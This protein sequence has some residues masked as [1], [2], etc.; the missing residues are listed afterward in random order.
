[1]ENLLEMSQWVDNPDYLDALES[2]KYL[3]GVIT[4]RQVSLNAINEEL[5]KAASIKSYP[6][7]A[8]LMIEQ[9]KSTLEVQLQNLAQTLEE[10]KNQAEYLSFIDANGLVLVE[11]LN[12]V[13][14][15]DVSRVLLPIIPTL[16]MRGD[17]ESEFSGTLEGSAYGGSPFLNIQKYAPLIE[18]VFHPTVM[19][20]EHITAVGVELIEKIV[21]VEAMKERNELVKKGELEALSI[22]P[23]KVAVN[24]L[25]DSVG[26]SPTEAYNIAMKL[27]R[28]S[29]KQKIPFNTFTN[30]GA[31]SGGMFILCTGENSFV[32][33]PFTE[34]GSIG[35]VSGY[36]QLTERGR[37]KAY[38]REFILKSGDKKRTTMHD[39]HVET[40]E[41]DLQEYQRKL[42]EAHEL[43][44]DFVRENRGEDTLKG[45]ESEMFHGGSFTAKEALGLG[46]ID[47][48]CNI[49][50]FVEESFGEYA[51]TYEMSVTDF[52]VD[53]SEVLRR[54]SRSE[55]SAGHEGFASS[56]PKGFKIEM[57]MPER[58]QPKLT[59]K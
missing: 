59:K 28:E 8:K 13:D 16:P 3:E 42:D 40:T 1:M 45:D 32:S 56:V 33:S 51:V 22:I 50:D 6:K 36:V 58:F 48:V 12:K 29:K 41:K 7:S 17:L 47:G 38:V 35:I 18:E 46:L 4:E 53:P 49:E 27:K 52:A 23:K 55:A 26:G 43:F 25:I 54:L 24:V 5:D 11:N 2:I 15:R 30:N 19:D 44:K 21:P 39:S 9:S 37:E 20:Y 14:I 10:Q 31:F 34:A 57:R